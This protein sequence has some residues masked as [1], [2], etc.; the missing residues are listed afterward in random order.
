MNSK[1]SGALFYFDTEIVS[2]EPQDAANI[3][4]DSY[5]TIKSGTYKAFGYRH[6]VDDFTLSYSM[7]ESG[8][9]IIPTSVLPL[10]NADSPDNF[11][12]LVGSPIEVSYERADV[13]QRID[14]FLNSPLDRVTSANMLARHFLPSYVSY[15][16]TYAGGSAP[17]VIAEDIYKYIDTLPVEQPAD[18]SEIEKLIEQRGGNPITPTQVMTGTGRCGPSSVRTKSV[19]SRRRCRI[20]VLQGSRTSRP[21]PMSQVRIR[22]RLES[23]ST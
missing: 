21:D 17:S 3:G 20:T 22:S 10:E 18:V 1:K 5:L 6:Q 12:S 11:I 8:K 15:D 13:V 4:Q 7:L 23:A 2:L 9:L 16:A 14:E 19:A